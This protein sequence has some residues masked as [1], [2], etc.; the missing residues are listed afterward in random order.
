M[1]PNPSARQTDQIRSKLLNRLGIHDSQFMTRSSPVFTA[2][3]KRR[4]RLLREMGIGHT[5]AEISPP[6]GS[7]KRDPLDGVLP[8]MEPLK[9]RSFVLSSSSVQHVGKVD[10]RRVVFNDKVS[11]ISIPKRNEYSKRIRSRIW[12]SASE[13]KQS[14]HRNCTEFAAEGWKWRDVTEDDGMYID[15]SSGE[16]VHPVHCKLPKPAKEVNV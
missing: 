8:H 6:D 1:G 7:A 2:A 10:N 14:V 15:A 16:L 13:L 12:N 4:L 5:V 9:D 11:V 3:E